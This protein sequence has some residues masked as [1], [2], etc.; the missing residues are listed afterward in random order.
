MSV[1]AACDL[2]TPKVRLN[3]GEGGFLVVE[4]GADKTG[5]AMANLL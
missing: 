3:V 4:M 1:K 2:S 5:W